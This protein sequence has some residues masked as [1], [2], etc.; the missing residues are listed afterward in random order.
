MQSL[1]LRV[2]HP[3][4][5]SCPTCARTKV[6]L[7]KIVIEIEGEIQK[8]SC[9]KPLT[10]AVMGCAVNGPGEAKHADLGIACGTEEGI[11]FEKG[12]VVKKVSEEKI[13]P[14]LLRRLRLFAEK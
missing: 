11:I 10:L 2:F 6:Q 3:R 9:T 14:E 8:I 7:E 4:L 1:G 13:I 5:I 12:K